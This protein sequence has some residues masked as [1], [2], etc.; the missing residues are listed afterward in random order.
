MQMDGYRYCHRHFLSKTETLVLMF[1]QFSLPGI[2]DK[3]LNGTFINEIFFLWLQLESHYIL[4][5]N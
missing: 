5:R 1:P 2:S 4:K 3:Q